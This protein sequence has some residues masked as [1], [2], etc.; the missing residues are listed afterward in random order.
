MDKI[1][2]ADYVMFAQRPL[3]DRVVSDWYSL[4]VDLGESALVD[5]FSNCFQVGISENVQNFITI[6]QNSL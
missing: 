1:L 5:K 2:N 3:D 6:V 4:F